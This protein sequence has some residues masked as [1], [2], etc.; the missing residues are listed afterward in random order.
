MKSSGLKSYAN[1]VSLLIP[2]MLGKQLR[3][4]DSHLLKK[5]KGGPPIKLI[6]LTPEE[7][8]EIVSSVSTIRLNSG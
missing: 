3:L 6:S 7:W 1:S 8:K 5:A 2:E 4:L